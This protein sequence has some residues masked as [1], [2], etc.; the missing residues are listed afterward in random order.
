MQIKSCRYCQYLNK[1]Y[2]QKKRIKIDESRLDEYD[3]GKCCKTFKQK[4]DKP[5]QTCG[6]CAYGRLTRNGK[7]AFCEQSKRFGSTKRGRNC[8]RFQSKNEIK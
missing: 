6:K 8:I 1:M 3:W 7:E 5:A 4:I 2:C